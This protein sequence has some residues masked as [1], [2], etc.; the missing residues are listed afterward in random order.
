[1]PYPTAVLEFKC[2]TPGERGVQ[3]PKGGLGRGEGGGGGGGGGVLMFQIDRCITS[4]SNPMLF[5]FCLSR[6]L[7]LQYCLPG[8]MN[9]APS[10]KVNER[11]QNESD[12]Q[13]APEDVCWLLEANSGSALVVCTG[14]L[15]ARWL[16]EMFLLRCG[17][18]SGRPIVLHQGRADLMSQ[19]LHQVRRA[20]LPYHGT[21]WPNLC[22][23]DNDLWPKNC[24]HSRLIFRTDFL[25]GGK[26]EF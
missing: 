6:E 13:G 24:T 26:C 2:P 4:S 25:N 22:L 7:R 18:R 1:M 10:Q 15:L 14:R 9:T 21:R 11:T 8:A 12:E 17:T 16:L 3:W 23:Q 20:T 5:L 19:R